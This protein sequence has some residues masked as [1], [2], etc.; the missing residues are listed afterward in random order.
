MV[1]LTPKFISQEYPDEDCSSMQKLVLPGRGI[2]KVA[3]CA[4]LHMSVVN[5]TLHTHLA[6]ILIADCPPE[7]LL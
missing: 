6:Y 3:S 1:K 7:Y 5:H 2:E 4:Q